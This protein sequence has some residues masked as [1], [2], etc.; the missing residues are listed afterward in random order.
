MVSTYEE[1]EET[2]EKVQTT[3]DE[4]F[5]KDSKSKEMI[6]F[7]DFNF[8]FIKWPDRKIYEPSQENRTKQ[9]SLK[10]QAQLLLDFADANF[11][12]QI[13]TTPTWGRNILDLC[14][15]NSQSDQSLHKNSKQEIVRPLHALFSH[16][17][18]I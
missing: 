2:L 7:G 13:V 15:T 12:E 8:N 18:Q 17:Y 6:C 10:R 16:E 5:D 9:S 1:F 14:F 3:I 11:M 4:V